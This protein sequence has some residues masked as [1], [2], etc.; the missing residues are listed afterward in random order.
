MPIIHCRSTSGITY[1]VIQLIRLIQ[2]VCA[3][4]L[5]RRPDLANAT[6]PISQYASIPLH[7]ASY[8]RLKFILDYKLWSIC[9]ITPQTA[10]ENTTLYSS[11]HAID[12]V[13]QHRNEV[14]GSAQ[15][16]GVPPELVAGIVAS[17]I[18]FDTDP[19]DIL[20]D[21]GF[22]LNNE[23]TTISLLT[24]L[25]I[26]GQKPLGP[27][28]ANIHLDTWLIAQVYYQDCGYD[29]GGIIPKI[30]SPGTTCSGPQKLD[31]TRR[32]RIENQERGLRWQRDETLVVSSKRRWYWN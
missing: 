5:E 32:G 29:L 11:C 26:A 10:A 22:R 1:L 6:I 20:M 12:W 24:A 9:L 30:P 28:T 21:A 23:W 15:R 3:R 17:E 13:N 25:F 4:K 31:T 7:K 14:I 18:D 19:D 2:L 27:G 16:H 8:H